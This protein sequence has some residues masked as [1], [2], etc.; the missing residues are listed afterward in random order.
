MAYTG[1]YVNVVPFTATVAILLVG[2]VFI[3]S[4]RNKSGDGKTKRVTLFDGY[5]AVVMKDLEGRIIGKLPYFAAIT[6]RATDIASAHAEL[7]LPT[8]L[9]AYKGL[10]TNSTAGDTW[11]SEFF[12]IAFVSP[13]SD[14]ASRRVV[15]AVVLHARPGCTHLG[16][17]FAKEMSP[18][19]RPAR[20]SKPLSRGCSRS[21]QQLSPTAWT[22]NSGRAWRGWNR[23]GRSEDSSTWSTWM[24]TCR[25]LRSTN[26]YF[27]C[28]RVKWTSGEEEEESVG[29]G[30]ASVGPGSAVYSGN[31]KIL[32]VRDSA[33]SWLRKEIDTFIP[34]Y[35]NEHCMSAAA[36]LR[37][38]VVCPRNL[39]GRLVTQGVF[40]YRLSQALHHAQR[41]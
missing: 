16:D 21:L 25:R 37:L 31:S 24:R 11:G 10:I 26:Q 3:L 22:V 29:P 14:A 4:K 19:V 7:L 15:E 34:L 17:I 8:S 27:V 39:Q 35:V 33:R 32:L 40:A 6:P 13:K 28:L 2:I 36:A 20:R 23:W 9:S 12:K 5:N 18:R 41:M 30:R 1:I 38:V